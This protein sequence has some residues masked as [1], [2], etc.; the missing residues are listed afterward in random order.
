MSYN[1]YLVHD[2]ELRTSWVLSW[3]RFVKRA[4]RRY[5]GTKLNPVTIT[6]IV[7]LH[8]ELKRT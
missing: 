3:S 1:M 5:N 6:N 4:K 2:F 7:V 8:L